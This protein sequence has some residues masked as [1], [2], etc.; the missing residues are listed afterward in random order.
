[1]ATSL[2][3]VVLMY[4][5]VGPWW[6]DLPSKMRPS[7]LRILIDGDY[8]NSRQGT[9]ISTYARTLAKGLTTLG[10]DV[11]WLSGASGGDKNEPLADAAAILEESL[12]V[13]GPRAWTQTATRMIGGVANSTALARKITRNDA[14]VSP[15]SHTDGQ[16][17][18]ISPE[19]FTR[20][21]YR[22]MLLR[23]FTEVKL[24]SPID[25]LHLTTPLPIS[26]AGAKQVVSILDLI[27][28]KLPYTTTDNKAEFIARVRK[29]AKDAEL[30]VT[31]SEASKT[32]IVSILDIDP[33]KVVVTYLPSDIGQLCDD[34]RE[35]LAHSLYRFGIRPG[36]YLLFVGAQE[37]KKNLKRLIEAYLDVDTAFPLVVAG[38]R[39]WMWEREVGAALAPLSDQ[40]RSRIKF[41]GYIDR[42][43][44]RRLYA[45]ALGLVYPSLYEGF[46]LPVLEAMISG[47]PVITSNTSSLPEVSGEAALYVDPFNRDDIRR[48]IE[49]LI[50]D[51]AL[52]ATLRS[53]GTAR[54]QIF[55]FEN[56]LTS[57]RAAYSR[58]TG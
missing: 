12:P 49:R 14:M 4:G 6:R 46:G 11:S 34:E 53:L 28:I 32:D 39:G 42:S 17:V 56:Y 22:H 54:A 18:H 26:L 16:T 47:C 19:L 7:F 45:G 1:V 10:H 38:P 31:I 29:C 3:F 33:S 55:T 50:G 15:P 37:P 51:P 8:A 9:G 2:I 23:R 44:L 30:I 5:W 27:P 25:V 13:R 24:S 41:T 48:A 58:L 52:R 35:R 21:H 40:A 36:E 57:L 20:A 43:D